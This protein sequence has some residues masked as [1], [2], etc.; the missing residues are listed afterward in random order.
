MEEQNARVNELI[1]LTISEDQLQAFLRSR[2]PELPGFTKDD[3]LLFLNEQEVTFGISEE[4]LLAFLQNP[5]QFMEKGA[6]V[7]QGIA[8]VHGEDAY[9]E[10]FYQS[11][12]KSLKEN[13]EG[14]V[15]FYQITNI[16]NVEKGQLVGKKIP[17]TEGVPGMNVKGQ[18]IKANPGKDTRVK[19]GKNVVLEPTSQAIYAVIS[20]QVSITSDEKINVFPIF[21]VN[22]DLDFGTGNIDFVGNVI[23]K[24]NVPT[25]FKVKAKGDI[26]ISGSVEGA[27]IEAEGSINIQSGIT[28]Q[29]KGHIIAGTDIVTNFISNGQVSAGGDIIV[30]QSIMH[31]TVTAGGSVICMGQK[32]LIVGGSVQAG[33]K[34]KCR[35]VGNAMAT[36]TRI[37]VGSDPKLMNRIREIQQQIKEHVQTIEK[38]D[39]ALSVLQQLQDK[40]GQLT[41]DKKELRMRLLNTKVQVEKEMGSLQTEL[42]DLQSQSEAEKKATIEVSSEIFQGSKLVF[43]RYIKYIKDS[44][45]RMKYYLDHV[46]VVGKPLV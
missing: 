37:E 3:L 9:T 40:M 22:G 34:V 23:I 30:A 36:P 25:G 8:P 41:D 45:K 24:G 13:D 33:K 14:K 4:S 43:G 39:Q 26:R 46:E 44:E 29:H 5:S 38:T 12:G 20:G 6:V 27:E 21:E 42:K 18:E 11:S 1:E 35:T 2:L 32:G 31:S 7:A 15:D 28:A 19:I 17:A 16:S 10:L